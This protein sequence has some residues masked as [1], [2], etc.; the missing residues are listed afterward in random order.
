MSSSQYETRLQYRTYELFY[1]GCGEMSRTIIGIDVGSKGGFCIMHTPEKYRLFATKEADKV[2]GC[3]DHR[4]FHYN[5]FV[6]VEQEMSHSAL[7]KNIVVMIFESPFGNQSNWLNR[8]IGFL[9][10]KFK[11]SWLMDEYDFVP[12]QSWKKNLNKLIPE[13]NGGTA[14]DDY[15]RLIRDYLDD[16]T[17]TDDQCAAYGIAYWGWCKYNQT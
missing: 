9:A 8:A 16:Q 5:M 13:M 14:K 6:R 15:K 2:K 1:E 7:S 4:I 3:S 11:E 17:L 12:P 10:W